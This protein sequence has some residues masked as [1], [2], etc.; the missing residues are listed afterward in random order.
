[1]PP[2]S[3]LS[4]IDLLDLDESWEGVEPEFQERTSTFHCPDWQNIQR[5]EN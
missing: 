1:M 3:N 5:K 2:D 4:R